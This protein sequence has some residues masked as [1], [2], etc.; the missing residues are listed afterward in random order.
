MNSIV[1]QAESYE[2]IEGNLAMM[3]REVVGPDIPI[4][5]TFDLHGNISDECVAQ[6]DF[7][8]P[9]HL[10]P[11]TDSY[12]RGVEA[13][14]MVPR[15][16]DGLVTTAHLE[17]VP[18]L[19]PLCMMCTQEGFPADTMNQFMYSLEARPGVL[20]G[21]RP[22]LPSFVSSAE[23][24]K[25]SSEESGAQSPSSTASHGPTYRLLVR[26][27]LS[28]RRTTRR[29]RGRSGAKPASGSGTTGTYSR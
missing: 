19:L 2:D 15:L 23:I 8:C 1:L 22:S 29:W 21:K 13:M 24:K 10:Y 4:V 12:E 7:M 16:L 11:H 18:T 26:L 20:D 27:W 3:I 25:T 28:P 6:Y 5:G 9:V 14:R 17:H